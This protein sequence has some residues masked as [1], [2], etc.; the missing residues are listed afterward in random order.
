MEA[1][2]QILE[3]NSGKITIQLPKS[4]PHQQVEV[5]VLPLEKST[6]TVLPTEQWWTE[7]K[8]FSE[9]L[10]HSGRTFS[11]SGQ[12]REERPE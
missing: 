11:D 12:L 8:Q 2:R 10:A 6:M 5:I 3:V 4:F 1:L 9:R 7:I